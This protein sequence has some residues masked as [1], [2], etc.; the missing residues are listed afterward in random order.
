MI[1]RE[2]YTKFVKLNNLSGAI[3]F[4]ANEKFEI[5]NINNFLSTSQK[6]LFKKNQKKNSKKK[7]IFTFDLNHNQK[8]IVFSVKKKK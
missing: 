2:K 5:K 7:N 8:I 3:I 6:D 4:F 1:L